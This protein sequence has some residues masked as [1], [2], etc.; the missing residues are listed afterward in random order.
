MSWS[1]NHKKLA[2]VL[3]YL[4]SDEAHSKELAMNAGIPA[5]YI[6]THHVPHSR[7]ISIVDEAAARGIIPSLID[8]AIEEFP[9]SEKLRTLKESM[10]PS[11]QK[12]KTMRCRKTV[13]I[14][15]QS[16]DEFKR[17]RISGDRETVT[18]VAKDILRGD[19][20]DRV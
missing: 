8:K 4:Y 5:E 13:C 14:E 1:D 9:N 2:S 12:A 20:K 11:A 16:D 3:A 7:W 18:K 19:P 15:I 17:I 6:S 10:W